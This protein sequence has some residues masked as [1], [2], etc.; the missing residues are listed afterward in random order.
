M[1]TKGILR[2]VLNTSIYILC[3]LLFTIFIVKFVCQK[4]EVVGESME[5]T[6]YDKDK[7]IV[8]KI[9]YRFK[10]PER[11]DIIVFPS[12]TENNLLIIKRVIGLPGEKVYIDSDGNIYI[13]DNILAEHYGNGIMEDAGAA[14]APIF[15]S[16]DEYF[17]LGDN[18]NH[19][20]DSRYSQ[21]G[22][23]KRDKIIGK[24]WILIWPLSEFK[25]IN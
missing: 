18:R 15:L 16:E 5:S 21:V 14:S 13:D 12:E 6:L 20:V 10:D 2:E 9:S 8:D 11:F 1:K 4:T 7:L 23:I 25:T 22:I 19:S 3:I 17:V 24:A